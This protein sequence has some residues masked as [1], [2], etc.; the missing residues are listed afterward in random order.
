[1][2]KINLMK[3]I[4]IY[5]LALISFIATAQNSPYKLNTTTEIAWLTGSL[6]G[7]VFGLTAIKNKDELSESEFQNLSKNDVIGFDR[8]AAGNF[9]ETQKTLSDIPF[10][11]SFA[12]P[13]LFTLNKDTKQDFGTI[14]IMY[15]EA[16]STTSALFTISAGLID[17]PRPLVYNTSVEKDERIDKD[18]QRS[19]YSGHVAATATATF[20]SAQVFADYFPDSKAKPYVWAGAALI[21]AVTGYFRI[22]GGSHFLSDVLLGYALGATTG[23][24]VPRLHRKK[25]KNL[26]IAPEIGFNNEKSIRLKYTF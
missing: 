17:R 23:I 25:N 5:L 2:V 4:T 1:M 13:F 19:F 6:G 16:L 15:L 8:W 20:F 7:T 10:Y 18:S 9:S 12:L 22:Q 26:T 3:K 14:G 24:L 21:P 11:S